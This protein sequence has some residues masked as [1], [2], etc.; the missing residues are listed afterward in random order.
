[1]CS[2]IKGLIPI[3]ILPTLQYPY[4]EAQGNLPDIFKKSLSA[5]ED[6]SM[7]YLSEGKMILGFSKTVSVLLM[8]NGP[9]KVSKAAKHKRKFRLLKM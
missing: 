5:F 3:L 6:V 2:S 9:G 8:K 1:M 4:L 7:H